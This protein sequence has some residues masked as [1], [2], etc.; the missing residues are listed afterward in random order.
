MLQQVEQLGLD[1]VIVRNRGFGDERL[2]WEDAGLLRDL[3]P[4]V[5]AFPCVYP[6]NGAKICIFCSPACSVSAAQS[7]L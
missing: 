1:N 2:R 3:L 7:P 5:L 6:F 4:G